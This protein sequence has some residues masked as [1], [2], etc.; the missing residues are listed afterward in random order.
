MLMAASEFHEALEVQ[1]IGAAH[2]AEDTG[3]AGRAFEPRL[4]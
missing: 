1:R 3:T 2:D 4:H